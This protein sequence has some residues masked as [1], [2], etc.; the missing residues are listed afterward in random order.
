M[1]NETEV[2]C[3]QKSENIYV[4]PVAAIAHQHFHLLDAINQQIQRIVETGFIIK[5]KDDIKLT[6]KPTVA[7]HAVP[8]TIA[9]I[10]GSLYALLVGFTLATMAFACELFFHAK[11]KSLS[12]LQ[13]S[14]LRVCE[15]ICVTRDRDAVPEIKRF[16]R[17]KMA[18]RNE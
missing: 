2:Y 14:M 9:N 16:L 11:K 10:S 4:Y 15:S 7:N 5:W 8:F 6:E 3:F 18:K 1:I 12:D 13:P 17:W